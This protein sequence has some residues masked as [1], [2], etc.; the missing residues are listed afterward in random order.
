MPAFP[1]EESLG[2]HNAR[3]TLTGEEVYDIFEP[4]IQEV[5][6]LVTRQIHSA[7]AVDAPA[8]GI[9]LVGGF[10]EN[11]YLYERLCEAVGKVEV[12]RPPKGFVPPADDDATPY[13]NRCT[14]DGLQWCMV[15]L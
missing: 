13:S 6:S 4:V 7:E 11:N 15:R 3:F 12:L 5:I 14:S 2:V 1:D 8:R 10:G 9:I